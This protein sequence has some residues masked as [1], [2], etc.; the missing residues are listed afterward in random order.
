MNMTLITATQRSGKTLY[1]IKQIYD[2]LNQGREVY[3]NI[4]GLN[5]E[6]VRKFDMNTPN[7]H[8][9]RD[10]PNDSVVIYDEC[11]EHPAFS[12]ENLVEDRKLL[13]TY[14]MDIG[15]TLAL[16]RH[17][18]FDFIFITQSPSQIDSR[19][20]NFFGRHLHLVRHYGLE[21]SVIYE[22]FHVK[23]QPNSATARKDSQ[24][25]RTFRFPK[26]LY[27]KYKSSESHNMK[28]SFPKIY[29]FYI[30]IFLV[31]FVYMSF[32]FFGMIN[33]Y[34]HP[35]KAPQ[36][37]TDTDKKPA[38]VSPVSPA[39]DPI[40]DPVKVERYRVAATF[41]SASSCRAYNSAGER[42]NF[43]S[44][45]EC[46]SYSNHE[47]HFKPADPSLVQSRLQA[48]NYGSSSGSDVVQGKYIN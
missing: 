10:L 12:S 23:T 7:V 14:R 18:G 32:K 16:H 17:F 27:S 30:A 43:I 19:L 38:L 25:T 20:Y 39:V 44:D 28:G 48:V 9:W 46:L 21:R 13:H 11:H 4:L 41:A 35:D 2:Y 40:I 26:H 5:I 47:V 24:F 36:Q 8:D 45:D 42:L 15:N 1:V 3:T 22:W 34:R 31:V 29:M 6:G 37:Q 33:R